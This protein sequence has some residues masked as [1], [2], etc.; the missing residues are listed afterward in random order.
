MLASLWFKQKL[1]TLLKEKI[2]FYRLIY[3]FISLISFSLFLYCS[4][5]IGQNVYKFEK[6]YSYI[7]F[8]PFIVGL[9]GIYHSSKNISLNEF[10]G[11]SQVKRYMTNKYSVTD[12]DEKMTLRIEG[13]YK[14]SRHP[15]YFFSIIIL[16]SFPEMTVSRL[17][18]IICIIIYFYIGSIFEEKKLVEV[19]GEQYIDYQKN[20][21]RIIPFLKL[22]A[23]KWE[24]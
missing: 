6:P 7:F 15:I 14:Y 5:S 16:L 23:L 13:P 1:T 20:V 10:I 3:N 24:G 18:I 12:L 11:I 19:F 8:L 4:P 22:K 17:V 9:L 2:A 21:N